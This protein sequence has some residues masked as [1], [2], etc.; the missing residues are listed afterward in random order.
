MPVTRG[1]EVLTGLK[2]KQKK[3]KNKKKKKQTS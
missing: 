1:T 3:T 2:K